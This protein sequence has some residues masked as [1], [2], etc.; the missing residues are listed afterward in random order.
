MGHATVRI[1]FLKKE[2]RRYESVLHRPDGIDVALEGGSYNKLGSRH[3]T[4]VPHD[5]AHL[6]VE[7]ELAL[8]HGVWG[9]LVQGGMFRHARVIA[10]RQA[11]HATERG[12]AVVAGAGDRIM[13]AEMLTRA[14]CDVCA[15][16]IPAEPQAIKR[17]LGARWWSDTVTQVALDRACARLRTAADSWAQLAP[18]AALV[19]TWP[20]DSRRGDGGGHGS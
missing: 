1:E 5:L 4:E 18:G 10:G 2:T 6:I 8:R 17:T 11:P 12:R 15:S 14:V 19:A 3:G 16:K 9:V 7:D 13:Q 20:G